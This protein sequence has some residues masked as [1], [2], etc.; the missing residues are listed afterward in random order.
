VTPEYNFGPTPALTNAMNYLYHEWSY[1]PVGFV[2]YGGLSGGMRGVQIAKG[3]ATTLKMMPMYEAVPIPSV[4]GLIGDEGGQKVFKANEHH[5]KGAV[6]LL[7]ET[8]KW[9]VAL[10]TIRKPAG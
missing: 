9:A 4:F 8:L 5:E 6:S 2:S 7:D 1:K 3:L 10:R